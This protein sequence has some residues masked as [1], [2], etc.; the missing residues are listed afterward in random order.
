MDK[1]DFSLDSQYSLLEALCSFSS[2]FTMGKNHPKSFASV[3]I[4]AVTL[5]MAPRHVDSA[6]DWV[7]GSRLGLVGGGNTGDPKRW[8]C[9]G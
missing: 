3:W 8:V 4:E 6:R 5:Q 9:V 1:T 2:P 7:R